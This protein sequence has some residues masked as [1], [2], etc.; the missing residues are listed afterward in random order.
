M[1][2]G[3]AH[4]GFFVFLLFIVSAVH[5]LAQEAESVKL[6]KVVPLDPV[7]GILDLF[8]NYS[9]VGLGE[10]F[11]TNWQGA[12]FRLLLIRDPRFAEKVNDI[13]VEYGTGRYQNIMDRY[14][15]GETVP[16][17]SVRLCWRETTQPVIWDAPIY[18]EF[19]TAVRTLNQSL[20]VENRLRVLLAD[21]PIDWSRINSREEL[22]QWYYDRMPER[23]WGKVNARDGYAV[24]VVEREVL[25]KNRKALA[26]FGD[27]HFNRAV[28]PGGMPG[29]MGD[30][31]KGNFIY[32]L[33][34][35]YPGS[36]V[37]ITS[38]LDADSLGFKHPEV[39]SWPKPSLVFL[40]GTEI[41]S[42]TIHGPFK[43]EEKHDA[44]LWMGPSD[45]ISFSRMMP[46]IVGNEDYYLEALRRDSLWIKQYQDVLRNLRSD[47]FDK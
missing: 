4:L 39:L 42:L 25:K 31:L 44:L 11:H 3:K 36:A 5:V 38:I 45:L 2:T 22:E 46:E 8:D 24:D 20:P 17:D 15:S 26:I 47:Y 21:P 27:Q 23:T 10:G 43:L 32:Q 13:V 35:M 14:I 37:S 16:M 28:L 6:N 19:F 9:I 12:T 1:T 29:F 41:G 33:E 40:K 34:R 7:D 30:Y 18:E